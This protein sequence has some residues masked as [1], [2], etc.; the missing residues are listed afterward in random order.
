MSFSSMLI[1]S[2]T[3]W[4]GY[5]ALSPT[6]NST[7]GLDCMNVSFDAK[8]PGGALALGHAIPQ[9][10]D[11]KARVLSSYAPLRVARDGFGRG[12]NGLG[13][14]FIPARYTR[15]SVTRGFPAPD[16]RDP[17]LRVRNRQARHSSL[18]IPICQ[19]IA[20]ENLQACAIDD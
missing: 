19:E 18:Q 11:Q 3:P 1:T 9:P 10:N 4:A 15:C 14:N 8:L 2:A 16:Y 12:L 7:S 5:T 13:I 6:L 17:Q 20:A